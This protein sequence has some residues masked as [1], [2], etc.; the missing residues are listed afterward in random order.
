MPRI[1][2][3]RT[4]SKTDKFYQKIKD[5][6]D[7]VLSKYK[8]TTGRR[9]LWHF[10]I[11]KRHRRIITSATIFERDRH[12]AIEIISDIVRFL[13][14]HGFN[15]DVLPLEPPNYDMWNLKFEVKVRV[16]T[17]RKKPSTEPSFS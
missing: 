3:N 12:K 2:K 10:E 4:A 14:S 11:D 9:I 6:L 15:L 13:K 5:K 17:A 16:P 1:V 7:S 8:E